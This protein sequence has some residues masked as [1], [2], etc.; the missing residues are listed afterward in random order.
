M[1]SLLCTP[2]DISILRRHGGC[3]QDYDLD[4]CTNYKD[5]IDGAKEPPRGPLKNW[6]TPFVLIVM[7]LVYNTKEASNTM[8]EYT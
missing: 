2:G 8:N 3:L 7:G 4:I 1:S 6:F 5:I